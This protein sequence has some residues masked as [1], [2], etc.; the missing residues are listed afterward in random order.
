MALPRQRKT[1]SA[2][3]Q[4]RSH[5]HLDKMH[6]AKCKNCQAPVRPHEV[7]KVCGFYRGRQAV[8]ISVAKPK[9]K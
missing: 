1:R 9:S 3:G 2:S 6:L 8:Q 5:Q 7:C 4:H